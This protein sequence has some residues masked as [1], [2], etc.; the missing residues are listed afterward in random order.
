[1]DDHIIH[2]SHEIELKR[3]SEENLTKKIDANLPLC[4]YCSRKNWME[5]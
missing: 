2:D 4:Y 1:M 5:H 3:D